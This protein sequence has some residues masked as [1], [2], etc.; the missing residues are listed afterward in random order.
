V[1]AYYVPIIDAAL[2]GAVMAL[3]LLQA[4]AMQGEQGRLS[5]ARV[6]VL[7][8]LGLCVQVVGSA[9]L[10]EAQVPRMWQAPFIAV[11]VANAVLFWMFIQALFNDDFVIEPLHAI[12]WLAVAGLSGLNCLV[13]ADS[14]SVV[15]QASL[16]LQRFAPLLFA[17]LAVIAAVANWRADLV[18][19][20][21]RLRA[22]ILVAGVTYTV[23]M[24]GVRLGSPQGRLSDLTGLVDIVALLIIVA[25]AARHL[26]RLTDTDLVA[27]APV[28]KRTAAELARQP[29]TELDPAEDRLSEALQ[30]LMAT[31]R[32]Y[33]SED[34][35][36]ARLAARLSVPEYRLR[37]LI[38]Q[39]LGYRNFNAYINA[40]RLAE[41]RAALADPG[42][43]ETPVLTIAL[44]A[45]F[46][47]I[48]PFNRAFKLATGRTPT[49]FRR[50]KLA[51]S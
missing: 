44:G 28:V 10:F 43:R 2:R 5:I 11:S 13:F 45:G 39:R 50:E 36:L 16:G 29:A 9:P 37:R 3:L 14:R 32:L 34:L 33:R 24:I 46:Q 20:R 41:A 23:A 6:G 12:A 27:S 19:R 1:P 35:S 40:F 30:R 21:R 26:L 25:V 22:F 17:V 42:Q 8:A 49:E 4:L 15:A 18:E 7:L 38:N 48:G 47:S 31:E 51:D